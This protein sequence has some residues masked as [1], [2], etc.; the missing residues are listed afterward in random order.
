MDLRTFNVFD[1]NCRRQHIIREKRLWRM[2]VLLVLFFWGA[3]TPFLAGCAGTKPMP[4]PAVAKILGVSEVFRR[5]QIVDMTLGKDVSFGRLVDHAASQDVVFVG[6][7]H[8]DPT[9]HLIEVQILQGLFARN[10]S[11]TLAMEFFQQDQQ[12]VLDGYTMGEMTEEEFLGKVDWKKTWGFPYLYYRP[13]MLMAKQQRL[14]VLALNAPADIVGKVA[15]DGLGSLDVTQRAQLPRDIDLSNEAE[16]TYVREA[17][18]E[19]EHGDLKNFQFFFEAQ[20]VWEETM[21]RNI[22]DYMKDHDQK[23]IVFSGNGH[24]IWKFGIPDRLRRRLPVSLVT[25]M[26][27]SLYKTASF[28][29]GIAD[30]IWFTGP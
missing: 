29:K 13:L 22:A 12:A 16:R 5:G 15:R 8:N 18:G 28:E 30:F 2:R 11:W 3:T 14:K 10:S 24:I 19:H 4:G 1:R 21:A 26:P 23:V 25:V 27:F 17:Y 20:C 9:D 7:I 6:E